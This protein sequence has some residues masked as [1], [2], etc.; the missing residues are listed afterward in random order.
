MFDQNLKTIIFSSPNNSE[1]VE[2]KC[3]A[4]GQPI[5]TLRLSLGDNYFH[6]TLENDSNQ[7]SLTVRLNTT[8]AED[9]GVYTCT[10]KNE[11]KEVTHHV[12]VT[13][14]YSS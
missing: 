3:I 5:P 2:I 12:K 9:F 4:I 6:G 1:P 14:T 10:A 11:L 13:S 7:A 8:K